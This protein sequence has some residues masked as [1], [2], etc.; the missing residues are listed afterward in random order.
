MVIMKQDQDLD[1]MHLALACL[2]AAMLGGSVHVDT[3]AAPAV[4]TIPIKQWCIWFLL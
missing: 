1:A 2:V 3:Y 4:L